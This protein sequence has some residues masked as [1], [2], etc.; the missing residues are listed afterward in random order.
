MS[1][2]A[3]LLKTCGVAC[4]LL[5]AAIGI[6]RAQAPDDYPRAPVTL[7]VPYPAGAATDTAARNFAPKLSRHLGQPVIVDNVGGAGGALAVQRLLRSKADGYTLLFGTNNETVLIP[8]VNPSIGYKTAEL[9]PIGLVGTTS[10]VLVANAQLAANDIDELVD[11]LR[12]HPDSLNL[13][14]PGIGTFQHLIAASIAQRAGV[15]W[16]HIPYKGASPLMTDL[17]GGQIEL[18]VVTLPSAVTYLNQGGLK[19][20]GLIKATRDPRLPD[21]ATINEGNSIKDM[22]ADLWLGL[23]APQGL[24][25]SVGAVLHTAL[26]RTLEDPEFQA[27]QLRMGFNTPAP[28]PADSFAIYVAEQTEQFAKLAATVQAD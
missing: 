9:Q 3:S 25:D 15:Q 26:N 27:A 19:S 17:L 24:P 5:A 28:G 1:Q 12:R 4:I 11:H 10:S 16:T 8:L 13:G 18:A 14:H 21:L 22:D 23:F 6:A 20:L 7:L 2:L